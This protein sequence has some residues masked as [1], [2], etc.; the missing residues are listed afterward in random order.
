MKRKLRFRNNL[1]DAVVTDVEVLDGRHLV[2]GV[3]LCA[4]G[5]PPDS[6]CHLTFHDVRNL[7]EARSAFVQGL[8][9]QADIALIERHEQRGYLVQLGGG[10]VHVDARS[11]SE[12]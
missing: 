10:V 11:L 9:V 8:S 7:E 4:C 6:V 12:L 2:L 3:R 5:N 1:H